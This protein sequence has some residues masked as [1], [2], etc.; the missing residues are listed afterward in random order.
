VKGAWRLLAVR[1]RH[2]IGPS[3]QKD[4]ITVLLLAVVLQ[5]GFRGFRCMMGGV[6]LMTVRQVCVVCSLFM[7]ACFM[8][9][10]RFLV[11]PRGVLVM[12]SSLVM[13]RC[14]F[15]GHDIS[16]VWSKSGT[17]PADNRMS[18]VRHTTAKG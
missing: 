12:F 1:Q 4:H 7:I 17:N 10:R 8:M 18:S 6:L 13:V 16:F 5:M 14:R 11:M 3:E 2:A 15:F 9:F